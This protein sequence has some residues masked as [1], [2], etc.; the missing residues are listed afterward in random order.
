MKPKGYMRKFLLFLLLCSVLGLIDAHSQYPLTANAYYQDFNKLTTAS[1]DYPGNTLNINFDTLKNWY[2][3][4]TGTGANITVNANNG[5]GAG[6]TYNYGINMNADR[7]LGC[8]RSGTFVS[9]FG[10]YFQNNSGATITSLSITYTGKTW[11]IGAL[12]RSDRLDF[13]YSTNATTLANGT[14]ADYNGLD[15]QNAPS[16]VMGNVLNG[17]MQSSI[18]STT[19]T[20]L[21]ISNGSAFFMRWTDFDAPGNDDGMAIDNLTIKANTTNPFSNAT[22]YF[23]SNSVSGFWSV[24]ASWQS[25]PDGNTWI[26]AT[27]EPTGLATRITVINGNTISITRGVA[28]RLLTINSGCKLTYAPPSFGEPYTWLLTIADDGTSEIDFTVAANGEYWLYGKQPVFATGAKAEMYGTVKVIDNTNN[29]S[30]AFPQNTSV[31]FKTGSV[32][33]WHTVT[34]FSTTSATYFAAPGF[35]NENPIFRVDTVRGALLNGNRD[36]LRIGS[37]TSTTF[38]GKLEAVFPAPIANVAPQVSAARNIKFDSSGTKIFRDGF[39]G[40]G[41]IIHGQSSGTFKIIGAAAEVVNTVRLK[42]QDNPDIITD[43]EVINTT[44]LTVSGSP[45]IS[46]GLG[47]GASADMLVSGTLNNSGANPFDITYCRFTLTGKIDAASSSTF[48]A[49]A[50]GGSQTDIIISGTGGSAGTLTLYSPTGTPYIELD[51][52]IMDR[53]TGGSAG[54]VIMGSNI[55]ARCIILKKGLVITDYNLLTW[56]HKDNDLS[57]TLTSANNPWQINNTFY[58]DSYIATCDVNGNPIT[59]GSGGFQI[60]NV[61]LKPISGINDTVYF[62]VGANLNSANRMMMYNTGTLDNYTVVVGVG[63]IGNTPAPVVE[64]IWYIAE[65]TNGGSKVIMKLFFTKRDEA[66]YPS[67]ANDEVE[68]LFNYSDIHVVQENYANNFVN[69]ASGSD[70]LFNLAGPT[71]PGIFN[72]GTEMYGQY[73]FTSNPGN[74]ITGFTR[75]AVVNQQTFILPVTLIN[76]K[77]YLQNTEVK[78][79]WTGVNEIAIDHY[80][81]ERSLDAIHFTSIGNQKAKGNSTQIQYA[82]TDA[83]PLNGNNFYRI[84]AIDKNGKPIYSQIINILVVNAKSFVNAYPNPVKNRQVNLLFSNIPYG[85]YALQVYSLNGALIFSKTAEHTAGTTNVAVQLPAH[86]KSGVYIMKLSNGAQNFTTK[87]IIK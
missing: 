20:G 85:N 52:L 6:D 72:L 38:N 21:S 37:T 14:W 3:L 79:E 8:L 29:E 58:S 27:L 60:N 4:E 51:T 32:F 65:G 67:A 63:D 44:T 68:T 56:L 45:Y 42:V 82:F 86:I 78:T 59:P 39:G 18:I 40:N 34:P 77:A 81:I 11:K 5:A 61:G 22:D 43:F 48:K 64:R 62:P 87:L 76:F 17:P 47:A 16:G 70:V 36:T 28:A 83:A 71:P 53:G 15:Y 50:G 54:N 80:E 55:T 66:L 2:F 57:S 31:L 69:V 73:T 74:G 12:N 84:K 35:A 25:S 30:D 9:T 19:F 33:L 41:H 23:R 13:Q 7:S 1:V 10:F 75:F 49:G 46:M 26:T 24:P